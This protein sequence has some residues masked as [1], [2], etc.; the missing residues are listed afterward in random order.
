MLRCSACKALFNA[1]TPRGKY[2]DSVKTSIVLSRYYLGL[3]GHRLER[4]QALAGVPLPD[5]TQW[6]LIQRTFDDVFPVFQQLVYLAAQ[7]D[8]IHHDDT[9]GRILSLIDENKTLAKGARYGIHST[10]LVAVGEQTII[11]YFTGRAHAGENLDKL[12]D[13]RDD[14]RNDVIQMSDALAANTCKRHPTVSCYC[15][16]HAVRKFMDIAETFP[17]PCSRILAVLSEVFR[18]ER[19]TKHLSPTE[20]LAYHQAHSDPL[21]T[22]LKAWMA[23]LSPSVEPNS[24]LAST[25]QYMT[26]RWEGFTRFLQVEGAPIDNNI[27]ERILKRLIF[28]RKNSFFYVNEYSAYVACVLTSIIMTAVT[29]GINV[30]EYFNTLQHHRHEV[31]RQPERW[32]PW[33]TPLNTTPDANQPTAQPPPDCHS[34][35]ESVDLCA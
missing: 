17:E 30:F 12:L 10:G 31:A 23:S 24:P 18:F 13:H 8:V 4:F 1:R 14:D 3:P 33:N 15:S 26:K 5:A 27:V 9:R 16:A 22:D 7:A 2:D 25:I 28:Q 29:A 32:L 6:D 20:R 34:T 21:L 35:E 11:L 19:Q